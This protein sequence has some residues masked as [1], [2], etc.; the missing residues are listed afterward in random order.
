[1]DL[2]LVHKI[3]VNV[4]R[5]YNQTQ[6]PAATNDGAEAQIALATVRTWQ[7]GK[8]TKTTEV[9][10]KTY[11]LLRLA[12]DAI[13]YTHCA[14]PKGTS[15]QKE[16]LGTTL[17]SNGLPEN[18]YLQSMITITAEKLMRQYP[19]RGIYRYGLVAGLARYY[20]GGNCGIH[21]TV[22]MNY[23]IEHAP[24]G[25]KISFCSILPGEKS[26]LGGDHEFLLLECPDAEPV[27]CDPYPANHPQAILRKDYFISS[28]KT[29][30]NSVIK[31]TKTGGNMM[32]EFYAGL[33]KK[34][35]NFHTLLMTR[36]DF[37]V[38]TLDE[39]RDADNGENILF[40]NIACTKDGQ[41]H[42]YY[43]TVNQGEVQRLSKYRESLS[44]QVME[45][46]N[47]VA[48]IHSSQSNYSSQN[49]CTL[50]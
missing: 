34:H 24:R 40:N 11:D 42:E 45:I 49:N 43:T 1:M 37:S 16:H 19:P 8:I 41:T 3:G 7:P 2:Y 5:S 27:V 26:I 22:A 13:R 17:D 29:Q 21:A 23:L 47:P 35:V 6:A 14:L 30:D 20:G 50:L 25:T 10:P 32:R 48:A 38:K 12:E 36:D 31:V 15:N 9:T 28:Q 4:I 46:E 39:M 44:H 18:I 33:E